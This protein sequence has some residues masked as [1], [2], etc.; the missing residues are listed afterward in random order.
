MVRSHVA[1]EPAPAILINPR[2]RHPIP[3]LIGAGDRAQHRVNAQPDRMAKPGGE[4]LVTVAPRQHA[5]QTPAL[6]TIW[7]RSLALEE[8]ERAIGG[9]LKGRI[10]G[11]AGAGFVPAV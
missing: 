1:V 3:L 11:M 7:L 4:D 6:A 10:V 8:V 9:K 5:Q 2:G